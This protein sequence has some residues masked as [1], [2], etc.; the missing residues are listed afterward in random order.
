MQN[1][2]NL[3]ALNKNGKQKLS[4]KDIKL[5]NNTNTNADAMTKIFYKNNIET[6]DSLK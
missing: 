6:V 2:S 4:V 1:K 5:S 3:L